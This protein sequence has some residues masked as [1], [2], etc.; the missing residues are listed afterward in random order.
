MNTYKVEKFAW[1]NSFGTYM[2]HCLL[3]TNDLKKGEDLI[4]KS[5]CRPREHI[6][7]IK[8]EC[9]ISKKGEIE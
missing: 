3:E 5:T 9:L 8:C 6:R 4:N 1:S 2:W 7:L